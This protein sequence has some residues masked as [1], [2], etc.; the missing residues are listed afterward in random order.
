MGTIAKTTVKVSLSQLNSNA[1]SPIDSLTHLSS[2]FSFV[3]SN[4]ISSLS[5]LLNQT[6]S[7]FFC[8]K[9]LIYFLGEE[10]SNS[11]PPKPP[12]TSK[13]DSHGG[14]GHAGKRKKYNRQK[15]S[16]LSQSESDK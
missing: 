3:K 15:S 10:T 12:V 11:A 13:A 14:G 7:P 5:L 1:F 16:K 4:I 8:D 9:S 2:P 6:L